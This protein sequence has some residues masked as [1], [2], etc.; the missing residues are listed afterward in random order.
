MRVGEGDGKIP[1]N[2]LEVKKISDQLL[3]LSCL[4]PLVGGLWTAGV[5]TDIDRAL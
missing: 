5:F 3:C 1:A 2:E 4:S